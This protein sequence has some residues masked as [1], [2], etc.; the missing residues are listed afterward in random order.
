MSPHSSHTGLNKHSEPSPRAILLNAVATLQPGGDWPI[1]TSSPLIKPEMGVSSPPG[2][3]SFPCLPAFSLS[4]DVNSQAETERKLNSCPAPVDLGSGRGGQ[5]TEMRGKVVLEPSRAC[6]PADPWS[7]FG[8]K[9]RAES[10]HDTAAAT[11]NAPGHG[12]IPTQLHFSTLRFQ[13]PVTLMCHTIL[14]QF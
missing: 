9:F 4:L 11:S 2:L 10:S 7:C 6:F 5:T 14:L 1:P 3:L 8:L 13:F 12:C